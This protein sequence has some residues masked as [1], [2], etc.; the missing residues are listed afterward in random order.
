MMRRIQRAMSGG[1]GQVRVDVNG[2][3]NSEVRRIKVT[4][5]QTGRGE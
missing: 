4:Q 3:V 5:K 1:F 2:D